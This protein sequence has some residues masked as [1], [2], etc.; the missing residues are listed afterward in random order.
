MPG[1][2]S[3]DIAEVRRQETGDRIETFII[4]GFDRKTVS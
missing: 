3:G 4:K 1:G 2:K